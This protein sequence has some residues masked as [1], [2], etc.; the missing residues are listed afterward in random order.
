MCSQTDFPGSGFGTAGIFQRI[1]RRGRMLLLALAS[2]TLIT[3]AAVAMLGVALPTFFKARRFYSEV[4]AKGLGRAILWLWG[5]RVLLH[6]DQPFPQT[7]TIYISNHTSTLDMFILLALGLPNTRFFLSGFL[8]KFVPLGMIGT[9]MGIFWTSPQ[10]QPNK[11]IQCFRE[12]ERILR[13]TGE[14]VYLSPEGQRVTTGQIG[15][16][17]KGAFHLATNL[18][19]PIVPFYIQIP[20]CVDP[21]IGIDAQPG[22]VHV[23][24]KPT[25]LTRGWK[26]GDLERNR[27]VVREMFV[28]FQEE[29]KPVR[30]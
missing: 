3:V 16:F 14:S 15:H 30:S 24:V 4:M 20:R 5:V 12:A 8:R 26:L 9:L 21:G 19:V 29:L 13:R 27:R 10:E 11:R 6:Q 18:G 7:Q 17:N 28:G 23:Y 25:I 1:V 2:L 22:R